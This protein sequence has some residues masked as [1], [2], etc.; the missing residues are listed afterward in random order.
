MNVIFISASIYIYIYIFIGIK[1]R[2]KWRLGQYL[3]RIDKKKKRVKILRWETICFKNA[4]ILSS[5]LSKSN[6][7]RINQYEK[8]I[9]S[10]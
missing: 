6:F 9:D 10:V 1:D 4:C 8:Q 2:T 5:G 3:V 7:N